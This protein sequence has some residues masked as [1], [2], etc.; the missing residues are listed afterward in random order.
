MTPTGAMTNIAPGKGG[1]ERKASTLA[2]HPMPG[3]ESG[4]LRKAISLSVKTTGDA[5]GQRVEI[6]IIARNVGHRV[7]TGFVDRQLI[8]VVHA[9]DE[10][11]NRVELLRGP[12][13][14]RSAGKWSGYAGALYA[15]QLVGAN[16]R[17]PSPFW[18][19]VFDVTDTRLKPEQPDVRTFV[20]AKGARRVSVQL[21]YRRFWQEV[22]DA[23]GWLDN[24]LLVQEMHLAWD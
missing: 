20:F 6:E 12:L 2:S 8:L 19:P 23:R 9:V 14:P 13:L 5:R 17:A 24:D 21:W 3:A 1:A 10:Q 22:A 11:N 7:P 16:N 15:K 4:M 18:L